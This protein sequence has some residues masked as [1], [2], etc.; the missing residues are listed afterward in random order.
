MAEQFPTITSGAVAKYPLTRSV[1]HRTQVWTFVDLTEQRF[2]KGNGGRAAF[3]LVY[4][5]IKTA[6]KETLRAFFAS[7]FGS[8]DH[9][10]SITLP[11][12]SPGSPTT[13]TNMQFLANQQFAAVN[14]S[15]D[16][17][18]VTLKCRQTITSLETAGSAGS[19]GDF[20][21]HSVYPPINAAGIIT[22]YPYGEEDDFVVQQAELDAGFSYASP[23]NENRMMKFTLTY[24]VISRAEVDVVET[25]F[26]A[27]RGRTGDFDF[28]DDN[29]TVWVNTRFDM[30]QLD[31]VYNEPGSHS[32]TVKLSALQAGFDDINPDLGDEGSDSGPSPQ[33]QST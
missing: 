13:Y 33:T 12:P 2:S 24:P 18:R 16:R 11:D 22:G 19:G 31:I 26:N 17:W 25:F 4:N 28:T 23:Q 14:I 8:Y 27:M 7:T 21:G 32:L 1:Q 15:P 5:N 3:T 6:D 10:W 20:G 30:D 9:T 29:G